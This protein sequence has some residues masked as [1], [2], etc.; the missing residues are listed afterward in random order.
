[1]DKN[2]NLLLK[3]LKKEYNDVEYIYFDGDSN[4][5]IEPFMGSIEDI[6]ID[7]NN[8]AFSLRD[9]DDNIFDVDYQDVKDCDVDRYNDLDFFEH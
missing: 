8:I 9:Q 5:E 4:G 3:E 2:L 1:M 7:G 6:F